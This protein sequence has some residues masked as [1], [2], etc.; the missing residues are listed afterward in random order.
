MLVFRIQQGAAS[1]FLV[2]FCFKP[3]KRGV[4]FFTQG[5]LAYFSIEK[6]T[7]GSSGIL[8]FASSMHGKKFQKMFP[9]M[10]L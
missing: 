3:W 1:C 8:G 2:A 4:L 5:I 9:Q 10:M 7:G 6:A